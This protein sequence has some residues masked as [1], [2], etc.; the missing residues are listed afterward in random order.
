VRNKIFISHKSNDKN[1]ADTVVHLLSSFGFS[2]WFDLYDVYP[3]NPLQKSINIGLEESSVLILFANSESL[4]SKWVIKEVSAF[5]E[6]KSADNVLLVWTEGV[7]KFPDKLIKLKN[8]P[9]LNLK[10]DLDW[11]TLIFCLSYLVDI[12]AFPETSLSL[13]IDYAIDGILLKYSESFKNLLKEIEES[14]ERQKLSRNKITETAYEISVKFQNIFDNKKLNNHSFYNSFTDDQ[15]ETLE[16]INL[17]GLLLPHKPME[18]IEMYIHPLGFSYCL[19]KKKN[20][21]FPQMFI[22]VDWFSQ[23]GKKLWRGILKF[24]PV[25]EGFVKFMDE[26]PVELESEKSIV[27]VPY[28]RRNIKKYKNLDIIYLVDQTKNNILNKKKRWLPIRDMDIHNS[29]KINKYDDDFIMFMDGRVQRHSGYALGAIFHKKAVDL[30]LLNNFPKVEWCSLL[31]K[32]F[33][34][35]LSKLPKVFLCEFEKFLKNIKYIPSYAHIHVDNSSKYNYLKSFRMIEFLSSFGVFNICN[36][37]VQLMPTYIANQRTG[38]T[39]QVIQLLIDQ[40]V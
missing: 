10:D 5:I 19:A 25:C 22:D 3:G 1:I 18:N 21:K 4:Q 17:I 34:S 14:R 12:N 16:I 36:E 20:I 28:D 39:Q 26:I 27:V 2:S 32:E 9:S 38:I 24:S 35:T 29:P 23:V 33:I 8:S 11:F 7:K 40:M 31:A 37:G 30:G 13:P 15:L 6:N